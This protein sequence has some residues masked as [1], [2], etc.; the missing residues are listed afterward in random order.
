MRVRSFHKKLYIFVILF[1]MMLSFC[2]PTRVSAGEYTFYITPSKI[3]DQHIPT[4]E[5]KTYSIKVG[6]RLLNLED[7]SLKDVKFDVEVSAE[8]EGE[9]GVLIDA[10][11]IISI[12]KTNFTLSPGTNEDVNIT[13][14]AGD[15]TLNGSYTAY[16]NFSKQEK[17]TESSNVSTAINN[18]LRVPIYVFIGSKEEYENAVIDY[19]FVDQAILIGNSKPTTVLSICKNYFKTLM[20]PFNAST[21]FNDIN[22]RP[23]YNVIKNDKQL[24]DINN[25]IYVLL[26][27]VVAKNANSFTDQKYFYYD[28][29]DLIQKLIAASPESNQIVLTLE[30]NKNVVIK[31]VDENISFLKNQ[32][33][34]MAKSGNDIT[35]QYLLDNLL[36]PK[37]LNYVIPKPLYVITVDSKS[38]VPLTLV[39]EYNVNRNNELFFKSSIISSTIKPNT[40]GIISNVITDKELTDGNYTI[41]GIVK[42]RSTS[43][44]ISYSFEVGNIRSTIRIYCILFLILYFVIVVLLVFI[45][46]KLIKKSKNK[47]YM[48]E[49]KVEDD[50]ITDTQDEN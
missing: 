50:V 34:T 44:N 36:V 30:N 14:N 24:L 15:T 2:F 43:K 38:T 23:Y 20:N 35:L 26:K 29:E 4:G 19:S 1:I 41:S 28:E 22:N 32:L 8:F 47:R 49:D 33:E 13:I 31:A 39:G 27:D 3:Y 7:E 42:M 5:S 11:N 16:I 9:E 48:Q 25:N 6:S 12:D 46:Y 17:P 10:S 40:S 21:V 45:C 37:N 18:V